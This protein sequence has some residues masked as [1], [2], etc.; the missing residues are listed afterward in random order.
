MAGTL[1]AIVGS[2]RA[3]V[4][5]PLGI[6]ASNRLATN[7]DGIFAQDGSLWLLTRSTT[8]NNAGRIH[9]CRGLE[10]EYVG[11]IVGGGLRVREGRI[12]TDPEARAR[13]D[14]SLSGVKTMARN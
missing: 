6:S 13:G 8:V 10:L 12:V 5:P 1:P 3:N 4:T 14:T 7:G 9:T 2:G 11:V